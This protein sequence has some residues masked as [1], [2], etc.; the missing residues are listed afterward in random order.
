MQ[1]VNG[2]ICEGYRLNFILAEEKKKVFEFYCFFFPPD[3]IFPSH[4]DSFTSK[5]KV[6]DFFLSET[7]NRTTSMIHHSSLAEDRQFW[8]NHS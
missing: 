4:T 8:L 5:Y 3:I 1:S 7:Q 2:I 6:C